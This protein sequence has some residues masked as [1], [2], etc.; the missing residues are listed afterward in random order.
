MVENVS[1]TGSIITHDP[2]KPQF[3][4]IYAA[5][6]LHH[7]EDDARWPI[8]LRREVAMEQPDHFY[9]YTTLSGFQGI[10]AAG[11]FWAS[12]NRF[13]NDEREMKDGALLVDLV[14]RH[15]I[16][17]TKVPG[18]ENVL[19]AV[20]SRFSQ[21]PSEG[22]LVACFSRTRDSLEQWRAYGANGGVCIKLAANARVGERTLIIGPEQLLFRAIYSTR[23]KL[24]MLFSIVGRYE[25][26]YAIDR[27]HWRKNWPHSHDDDF[28]S[29]LYSTVS[30]SIVGFKDA[31]FMQESEIRLVVPPLA[32]NGG[33]KFRATN[34]GLVPYVCTADHRAKGNTGLL[35]IREVIIGPGPRQA[36]IA[37]SIGTFLKHHGY[38][39]TAVTLSSVP[40]RT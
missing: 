29:S 10:I 25:G 1:P 15:R 26:E 9:H 30:G 34:F 38:A 16:L 4:F 18:F 22:L 32:Y 28:A 33:L 13:L 11:G 6:P 36:L 40:Y 7:R 27:Q 23:E 8:I 5:M 3:G 21:P 12:D 39:A 37:D 17:R 31:A 20:A 35:P 14:M 2:D 24:E 19:K